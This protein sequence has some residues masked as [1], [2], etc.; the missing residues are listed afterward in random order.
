M[1]KIIVLI[2]AVFFLMS[3]AAQEAEQ[4]AAQPQP[5]AEKKPEFI[6]ITEKVSVIKMQNTD[7]VIYRKVNITPTEIVVLEFPDGILLEDSE[8]RTL[9]DVECLEVDSLGLER[10]GDVGDCAGF[11]VDEYRK[12]CDGAHS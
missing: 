11:V 2:G 12:L 3:L 10:L 5:E 6:E 8:S 1:K 4:A 9:R 7:T